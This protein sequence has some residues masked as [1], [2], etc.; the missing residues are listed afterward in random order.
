MI[1]RYLKA[2]TTKSYS[3][4]HGKPSMTTYIQY[5]SALTVLLLHV[6]VIVSSVS[7]L[8]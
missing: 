1:I 3:V 7:S 5:N 2:E 6:I 4:E 8:K